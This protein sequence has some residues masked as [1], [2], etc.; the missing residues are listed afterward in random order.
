MANKRQR[1]AA[2][3]RRDGIID[4]AATLIAFDGVLAATPCRVGVLFEGSPSYAKKLYRNKGAMLCLVLTRHL[5]A[6]VAAVRTPDDWPGTPRAQLEAMACAYV[7]QSRATQLTT[8]VHACLTDAAQL[9]SPTEREALD[10]RRAWLATLFTTAITDAARPRPSRPT[11]QALALAAAMLTL[12]DASAWAGPVVTTDALARAATA[13][14]C[15]R[16]VREG[17]AGGVM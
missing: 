8:A 4:A 16:A 10:V 15:S 17:I 2:E 6:L 12:L 9:L 1:I 7:G 5:D 13:M 3:E 14:A 11:A